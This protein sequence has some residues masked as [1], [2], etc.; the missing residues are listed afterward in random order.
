VKE[1]ESSNLFPDRL[2]LIYRVGRLAFSSG[3]FF[4]FLSLSSISKL[5]VAPSSLFILGIY[6]IVSV[7]L[8]LF[9]K[10]PYTFEF[11]LDE[12]VI[13]TLVASNVLN[14]NFFSIFL[15]F[16]VFFSTIILGS[17]SGT[18]SLIFGLFLHIIFFLQKHNEGI[19]TGVQTVL[20]S[21]ALIAMFVAGLK[22]ERK[23][24]SQA[25]Y[26]KELEKEKERTEFYKRLYEISANM[27]HEIKNPL[28]SIK[29]ALE[30]IKEGKQNERLLEIIFKET[31]RLDRIVKDFL[32][33]SRPSSPIKTEIFLPE[34]F[35]E[36]LQS[37]QH[38]GKNYKLDVEPIK[39][40]TDARGFYSTIENIVRN[41]FQWADSKVEI[42]CH[43]NNH[44]LEIIVEDDGPGIPEEEREKIF[45]PFYSRNPNGSGLGLSIVNKFILENK[46]TIK[47]EKSKLG[48]AKF[49]VR[50][51]L[52]EEV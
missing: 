32:H 47:V 15:I 20:N 31:D 14:Y 1:I 49:V 52:S 46:G 25:F 22:L 51:P 24:K 48:G 2:Y 39:F 4:L 18:T 35:Q 17:I 5:P 43:K 33:L 21:T 13:F 34:A 38:F 44:T 19:A 8:L 10:K 41:A 26:I 30:L 28:A 12:A 36:I 27:A 16:P 40:K 42:H 6:V 3:I 29:G 50:L 37:L 11:L 7:A 23:L 9:S 45:E